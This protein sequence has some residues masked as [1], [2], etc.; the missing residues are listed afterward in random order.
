M[1]YLQRVRAFGR[2]LSGWAGRA[3]GGSAA[4]GS[5]RA[6][7]AELIV[8]AS[9]AVGRAEDAGNEIDGDAESAIAATGSR[10]ARAGLTAQVATSDAASASDATSAAASDDATTSNTAATTSTGGSTSD[11]T[12]TA[13]AAAAASTAA[14]AGTAGASRWRPHGGS[15]RL[16][17]VNRAATL[18]MLDRVEALHGIDDLNGRTDADAVDDA[19]DA[20]TLLVAAFR[21]DVVVLV[22]SAVDFAHAVAGTLPNRTA[23]IGFGDLDRVRTAR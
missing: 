17:F 16:A 3:S 1:L 4:G 7:L 19:G 12:D 2:L 15:G 21:P 8:A 13:R 20:A 10:D 22:L 5:K 18:L 9:E 11:S 6:G 23:L 14:S